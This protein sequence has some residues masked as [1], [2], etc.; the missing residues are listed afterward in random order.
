MQINLAPVAGPLLTFLQ[1]GIPH[2]QAALP[3]STLCHTHPFIMVL[4]GGDP[5]VILV[6]DRDGAQFGGH[7]AGLAHLHG[8]LEMHQGLHDGMFCRGHIIGQGEEAASF[9]LEGIILLGRDDP[10]VPADVLE[11]HSQRGLLTVVVGP[12]APLPSG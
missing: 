10:A 2:P 7:T 12:S 6:E 9:T 3:A 4:E 1:P 11:V 8:E 5:H